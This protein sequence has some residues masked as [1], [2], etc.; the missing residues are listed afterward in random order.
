MSPPPENV[1]APDLLGLPEGLGAGD[2]DEHLNDV[3]S[4]TGDAD[5][6]ID[7][8]G[9]QAVEGAKDDDDE[10]PLHM[11]WSQMRA[12]I[13]ESSS[14]RPLGSSTEPEATEPTVKL[15]RK[16]PAATKVEVPV[17]IFR[18]TTST[19]ALASSSTTVR[20]VRRLRK[21]KQPGTKILTS[22]K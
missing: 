8:E 9:D 6:V 4:A 11:S 16:E 21:N 17:L 14:G 5:D 7:L 20:V 12:R 1:P 10:V 18:L 13:G 15:Q 3:N 19:S 2:D 22:N